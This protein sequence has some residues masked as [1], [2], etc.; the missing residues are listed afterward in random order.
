MSGKRGSELAASE[1]ETMACRPSNT[2]R[3]NESDMRC[4]T[5][6]GLDEALSDPFFKLSVQKYK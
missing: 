5:N 2:I 4:S 1:E 6:L 3:D